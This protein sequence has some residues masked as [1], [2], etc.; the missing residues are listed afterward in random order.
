[1]SIT[2][3]NPV[4]LQEILT[5]DE[6]AALLRVQPSFIYER[7]RRRSKNP[8]PCHRIGKYLRF[9]R[10]EIEAWFDGCAAPGKKVR[11]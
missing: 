10:S 11:R 4:T 2:Q 6:A 5:P 8:I 9:R 7:V 3:E 1:M